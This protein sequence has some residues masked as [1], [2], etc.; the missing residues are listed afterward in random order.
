GN[1]TGNGSG[2][3]NTSKPDMSGAVYHVI[4]YFD[5]YNFFG[6]SFGNPVPGQSNATRSLPTGSKIN[7]LGTTT[8]LLKVNYYDDR[9]RVVQT[10]A[11]NHL[12]GTDVLDSSYDFAGTLISSVRNHTV[13]PT[14]TMIYKDFE[15]DHVRRSK[16]TLQ[17]IGNSG[18]PQVVL[19]EQMYND[20]GQLKDKKLHNSLNTNAFTYNERGWLKTITSNEFSV[21][22]RYNDGTNPQFSGNIANQDWGSNTTYPNTFTYSYDKFNRLLSAVSTG[23]VMSEVISY[24]PIGNIRTMNRDGAGNATYNYTGSRLMSITGGGL[25]AGNWAYDLNGN[26]M[27]DGRTGATIA[28]NEFNLPAT[29]TK[30]GLNLIYTY[31][32]VGNKL[33]KHNGISATTRHY[34]DGIEYDGTIIDIIRTGEGVARNNSGVYSYEYNLT[35]HLG[36]PRYS[37]NKHPVTGMIQRLQGD[38]FYAFGKRKSISPIS[39][40]N[41]YL[42]TG[43]EIQDELNSAGKEGQYDFIA[44]Y[45]DAEIGRWNVID[46]AN[47]TFSGYDF[48]GNNPVLNVDPDGRIFG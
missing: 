28:Y 9:G 47:Q 24:D 14:T 26:A 41:K 37:F 45:Y 16:R 5:D 32:A 40:I 19:S 17:K 38:D 33:T 8:L 13:G 23:V 27:T 2:Y 34:I 48:C 21:R 18:S 44:R 1:T 42:Y 22:L 3:T 36:N 39:I 29:A 30:T 35:D 43:K 46:P 12:S 15:Y 10:K 6:N 25:A 4:N 31:D 20:I 11:Q 7:V